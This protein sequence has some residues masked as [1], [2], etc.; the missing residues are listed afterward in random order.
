MSCSVCHQYVKDK[1]TREGNLLICLLKNIL[2]M[3]MFS[4]TCPLGERVKQLI[5]GHCS[6]CTEQTSKQQHTEQTEDRCST[7]M[8]Y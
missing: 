6:Y 8:S 2:G 1:V 7:L 4:S 5:F 3:W